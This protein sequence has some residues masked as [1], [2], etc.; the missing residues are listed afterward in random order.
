[1]LKFVPGKEQ[2]ETLWRSEGPGKVVSEMKTIHL[3]SIMVTPFIE[4]GYIYGTCSYGQF[5]C[6]H[7]ETGERVWESFIPTGGP[8]PKPEGVRWANAF[9]IKNGTHFFI[10]NEKGDL[11]LAN[12][13][14][15]GYEELGR[16]HLL[17]P[18]NTSPGRPVVWSHPALAYKCVFMR[19]DKELV[20]A[21]LG[22]N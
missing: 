22:K 10:P 13:S 6:L 20:C 18:L 5:R 21:G 19:N 4:G 15:K 2:P 14:P 1:M 17:D 3:N 12:L 11:I 16:T 9:V 7:V 8:Y